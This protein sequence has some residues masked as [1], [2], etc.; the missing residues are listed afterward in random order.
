[1]HD[2]VKVIAIAEGSIAEDARLEIFE[3][4][5]LVLADR[6]RQKAV[7]QRFS[8]TSDHAIPF[9]VNIAAV[10]TTKASGTERLLPKFSQEA[11]NLA[12]DSLPPLL[13]EDNLPC[14]YLAQKLPQAIPIHRVF[15]CG[16]E[17]I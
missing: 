9:G 3:I 7:K 6:I 11:F 17:L 5:F 4:P 14:S 2:G 8:R 10:T 1:M 12:E 16:Q 15:L 13:V